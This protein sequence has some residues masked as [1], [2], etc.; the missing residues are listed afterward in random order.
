MTKFVV[1]SDSLYSVE[2]V[3]NRRTEIKL[4]LHYFEGFHWLNKSCKSNKSLLET[5]TC[6][7]CW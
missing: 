4:V 2:A 6:W 5:R 1:Y 7:Y 3:K